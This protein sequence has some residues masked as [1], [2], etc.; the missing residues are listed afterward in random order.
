MNTTANCSFFKKSLYSLT[1]TSSGDFQSQIQ[2]RF[3]IPLILLT[4]TSEAKK[5]QRRENVFSNSPS[6]S[7]L[8]NSHMRGLENDIELRFFRKVPLLSYRNI[9]RKIFNINFKNAANAP[10]S[11]TATSEAKKRHRF[12]KVL[13]KFTN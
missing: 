3:L 11:L 6:I 5:R 10:H 8:L 9:E 1:A 7:L 2:K 12:L 4:A 13:R